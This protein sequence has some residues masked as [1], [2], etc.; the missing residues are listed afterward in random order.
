MLSRAEC[1]EL[2]AEFGALWRGCRPAAQTRLEYHSETDLAP[3]SQERPVYALE[4][5]RALNSNPSAIPCAPAQPAQNCILGSVLRSETHTR[6]DVQSEHSSV[7]L[8]VGTR[9]QT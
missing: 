1:S 2:H 4:N 3:S 7:L 6:P 9:A 5:Q 8:D